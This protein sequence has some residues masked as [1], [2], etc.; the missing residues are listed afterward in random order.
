MRRGELTT[1]PSGLRVAS[2]TLP[3]AQSLSVGIWVNAGA[4]DERDAETG[5]A[6]MLEH[7]AFK[8]TKRRSA[9]DI[10]TEVENV[11]GYMNAHTSRRKRPIICGCFPNILIWASTFFRTF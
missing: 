3:Q 5:I 7:M 1:L 6:H 11:G 2:R 4:R 9:R 10:A 8:G